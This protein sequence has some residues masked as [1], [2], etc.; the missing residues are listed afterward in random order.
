MPFLRANK[1]EYEE[2]E[3]QCIYLSTYTPL[4]TSLY[5]IIFG[6]LLLYLIKLQFLINSFI[7]NLTP[8]K[9]LMH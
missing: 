3:V 5:D 1:I 7:Q 9:F 4:C 8:K 6:E 2:L